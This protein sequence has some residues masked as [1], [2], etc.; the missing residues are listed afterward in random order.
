VAFFIYSAFELTALILLASLLPETREKT[1][2][3]SEM[4]PAEKN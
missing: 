3:E 2:E 4:T 1:L